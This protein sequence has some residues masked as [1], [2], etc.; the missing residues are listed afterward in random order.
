MTLPTTLILPCLLFFSG[1]SVGTAQ[2]ES[3]GPT[4]TP[5]TLGSGVSQPVEKK[6]ATAQIWVSPKSVPAGGTAYVAVEMS[7]DAEWHVYWLYSGASGE[8]TDITVTAPP[9]VTVGSVIFP[10]PDR[11]KESEGYVYGYANKALFLVP[12][13]IDTAQSPGKITIAVDAFWLVC[14]K[15]CLLGDANKE[16]T[17]DVI[18]AGAE[19]PEPDAKIQA[20]KAH[21]P[22]DLTTS[23]GFDLA[24]GGKTL[25]L[26]GPLASFKKADFFP[27]PVPG[28]EYGT[29]KITLSEGQFEIDVPVEIDIR[30]MLDEPLELR[31]LV[32]LG[33]KPT[34]PSYSF[35][36]SITPPDVPDD[37][38]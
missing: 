37:N 17:L 13:T 9:G 34:D 28:I 7:I 30:N 25:K 4:P 32:V 19:T 18:A 6:H 2:Q 29:P 3:G 12:I 27:D 21:Q 5:P 16:L 38:S 20:A 26:S 24:F 22:V 23:K 15:V 10:R 35:S 36:L 1:A 14:R 33:D 8:P 11:F 31:G